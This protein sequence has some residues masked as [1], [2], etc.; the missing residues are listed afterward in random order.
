MGCPAPLVG[1]NC[2]IPFKLLIKVGELR[3][4]QGLVAGYGGLEVWSERTP[5]EDF[6]MW[7]QIVAGFGME[8]VY[9]AYLPGWEESVSEDV[10][11]EWGAIR[12]HTNTV[13]SLLF[14]SRREILRTGSILTPQIAQYM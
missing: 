6:E 5:G 8:S 2:V 7:L 1:H 11:K 10:H 4:R 12:K 3:R 13:L 9:I 14:N